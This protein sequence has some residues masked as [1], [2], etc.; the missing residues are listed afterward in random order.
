[1]PFLNLAE[2]ILIGSELACGVPD[3]FFLQLTSWSHFRIRPSR[4]REVHCSTPQSS[5][6]RR[7]L[8]YHTAR[9]PAVHAVGI[10]RPRAGTC[11]PPGIW[12]HAPSWHH[13]SWDFPETLHHHWTLWRSLS[14]KYCHILALFLGYQL[15]GNQSSYLEGD[16]KKAYVWKKPTQ[17]RSKTTSSVLIPDSIF[18]T[19]ELMTWIPSRYTGA[20]VKYPLHKDVLWESP[21]SSKDTTT[22]IQP[23]KRGIVH[24]PHNKTHILYYKPAWHDVRQMRAPTVRNLFQVRE[25]IHHLGSVLERVP[26]VD[27][28]I[29]VILGMIWCCH[30][31]SF[32][33][34]LFLFLS[35]SISLSLSLSLSPSASAVSCFW[36]RSVANTWRSKPMAHGAYQT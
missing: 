17:G 10:S 36:F 2:W 21:Q 12:A 4:C 32:L 24:G 8:Q 28:A 5:L 23:I 31:V 33:S 27:I 18:T 20:F 13:A 14:K 1:M 9:R 35:L 7:N 29:Q 25:V 16:V 30:F 26:S 22:F 19:W 11:H 3:F 6:A 15:L 34:H